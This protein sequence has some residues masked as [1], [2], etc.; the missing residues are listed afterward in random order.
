MPLSRAQASFRGAWNGSV[1]VVV[2]VSI[3]L[4]KQLPDQGVS[5]HPC[6]WNSAP[7][8]LGT[9]VALPVHRKI[10]IVLQT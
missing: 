9:A 2:D 1:D 4:A 10:E 8:A 7:H 6:R 5:L 3:L